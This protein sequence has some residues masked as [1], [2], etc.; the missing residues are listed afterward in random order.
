MKRLLLVAAV[1]VVSA[2]L[3]GLPGCG[4]SEEPADGGGPGGG[5]LKGDLIIFHAGSLAV[6]FKKISAVFMEEHPNVKVKAEAAG[7]RDMEVHAWTV[8]DPDELITL[9]YRGIANV[10]TDDPATMRER[11]AEIRELSPSARILLRVRNLLAD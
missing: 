7:S 4:K 10:I 6:P 3:I 2:V 8:N 11:L 5:E 1:L 9:L